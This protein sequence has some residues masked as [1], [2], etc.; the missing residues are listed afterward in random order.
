MKNGALDQFEVR[1]WMRIHEL[2]QMLEYHLL[3]RNGAHWIEV[4][5]R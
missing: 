3:H 5:P 2:I 1:S 4:V